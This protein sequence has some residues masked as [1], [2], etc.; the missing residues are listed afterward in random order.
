MR[1]RIDIDVTPTEGADISRVMGA[2]NYTLAGVAL[3]NDE[4]EE[5][6]IETIEQTHFKARFHEDFYPSGNI[7]AGYH[8]NELGKEIIEAAMNG[9]RSVWVCGEC[10]KHFEGEL[11][12]DC[13]S[14]GPAWEEEGLNSFGYK[15]EHGY[16]ILG[17]L[18]DSW[19]D[20][21]DYDKGINYNDPQLFL[22]WL[23]GE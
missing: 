19:R 15:W 22:A 11:N 20:A 6:T 12:L 23:R 14:F 1:F 17:D 16:D 9:P 10:G 7:W 2:F 21:M 13:F 4:V 8:V 18:R 5:A 3:E